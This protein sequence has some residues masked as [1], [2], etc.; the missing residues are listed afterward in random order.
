MVVHVIIR[1][2]NHNNIHNLILYRMAN[3]ITLLSMLVA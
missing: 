1:K 2:K 3:C